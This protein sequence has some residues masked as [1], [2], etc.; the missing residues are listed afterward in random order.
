MGILWSEEMVAFWGNSI[1][2]RLEYLN[3]LPARKIL[4]LL[5]Q[6]HAD[7]FPRQAKWNEDSAVVG[8][9]S[10]RVA[11]VGEGGEGDFVDRRIFHHG[12]PA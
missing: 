9:A 3:D 7:S 10:H 8:Q 12:I 4:F 5:H 6:P 2:R 11:A 1:W